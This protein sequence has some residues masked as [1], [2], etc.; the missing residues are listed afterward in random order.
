MLFSTDC[1]YINKL[2][3]V[4]KQSKHYQSVHVNKVYRT[5]GNENKHMKN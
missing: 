2:T 3:E 5:A 4:K 1:T